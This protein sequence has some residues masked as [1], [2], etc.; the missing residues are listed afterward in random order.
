MKASGALFPVIVIALTDGSC[1]SVYNLGDLVVRRRLPRVREVR[2]SNPIFSGRVAPV[3][4]Q[5]LTFRV[6]G[7]GKSVLGLDG[8]LSVQ[9]NWVRQ[10]V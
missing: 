2:G 7:I 9:Y 8:S 3:I 10:Q 4:L 5:R 6:P 1:L